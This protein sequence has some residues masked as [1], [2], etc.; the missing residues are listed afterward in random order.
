MPRQ[1]QID[2]ILPSKF[3]DRFTVQKGVRQAH[4]RIASARLK[5]NPGHQLTQTQAS[6]ILR[7]QTRKTPLG[8]VQAKDRVV[9][10]KVGLVD[11]RQS[12]PTSL[13][14]CDI[15]LAHQNHETCHAK[16]RII[17]ERSQIDKC[18]AIYVDNLVFE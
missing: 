16:Q 1:S 15:A 8:G 4:R 6:V 14:F 5:Q 9:A 13:E 10:Y 12:H 18:R 11:H 17:V 7:A 3:K 2:P